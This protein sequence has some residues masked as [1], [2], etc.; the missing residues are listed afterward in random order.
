M[1]EVQEIE[2]DEYRAS[3]NLANPNPICIIFGEPD[4]IENLHAAGAF[5][6]SK[7]KLNVEHVMKLTN[8]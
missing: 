2:W 3:S 7:S 6:A 1:N 8:E 4:V 5:H